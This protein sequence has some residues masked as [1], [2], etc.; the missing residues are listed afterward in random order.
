MVALDGVPWYGLWGVGPVVAYGTDLT[1]SA[2][3]PVTTAINSFGSW[4]QIGTT[5]RDHTFW[6]VG[7]DLLNRSS[8]GTNVYL[9]EI[10]V[11]P[12]GSQQSLGFYRIVVNTAESFSAP[13]P[14]FK[15][16]LPVPAGTD[17]WAR[18]AAT[19]TSNIGVIVYAA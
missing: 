17:V 18:V 6:A 10:G 5:T 3:T 1:I 2:G 11:G 14:M 9:V 7:V 4:S 13:F 16:I 8:T 15:T 12:S 19:E